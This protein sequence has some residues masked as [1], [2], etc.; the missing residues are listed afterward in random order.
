[1]NT[2]D[3]DKQVIDPM[4]IERLCRCPC[5]ACP[6]SQVSYLEMLPDDCLLA[7]FGHLC[8]Q[9]KV[10]LRLV[11]QRWCRLLR[12]QLNVMQKR[13][14]VWYPIDNDVIAMH[15]FQQIH[16]PHLLPRR[17][18]AI[19]NGNGCLTLFKGLRKLRLLGVQLPSRRASIQQLLSPTL[20]HLALLY[21]N[22]PIDSLVAEAAELCIELKELELLC[23]G[24]HSLHEPTLDRVLLNLKKLHTLR[25]G[26]VWNSVGWAHPVRCERLPEVAGRLKAL[27]LSDCEDFRPPVFFAMLCAATV[28]QQL[29]SLQFD[30]RDSV[31]GRQLEY[32]C[33]MLPS[34]ESLVICVSRPDCVTDAQ[35]G[36]IER[37]HLL[38]RL[39][40]VLRAPVSLTEQTLQR[41][42][43]G[44]PAV[45]MFGIVHFG[46]LLGER[47]LIHLA[48]YWPHLETLIFRCNH[49]LR[50][51]S[52]QKLH[53]LR[54]LRRLYLFNHELS[55]QLR[56]LLPSL[57]AIQ[58]LDVRSA[59]SINR[60][61]VDFMLD[62]LQNRPN[63]RFHL[64]ISDRTRIDLRRYELNSKLWPQLSIHRLCD[65]WPFDKYA[66]V[67]H[68]NFRH[69]YEPI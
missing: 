13:M 49:A 24:S 67:M 17:S 18:V 55:N 29:K 61:T 45:R 30:L 60:E 40:L 3:K 33:L 57:P 1:M 36:H 37:L 46:P 2:D 12:V 47:T 48:S 27:Q 54:Q 68:E 63:D 32:V 66:M 4:L 21:C 58:L 11:S 42:M 39:E 43:V 41:I 44:C 62:W 28:T 15:D 16:W 8:I 35:F 5:P 50:P 9:E 10:R 38:Q 22:S 23:V 25:I 51:A 20:N 7:V 19:A 6:D 52:L 64:L 59:R 31:S 69:F 56:F 65:S 53:P 14:T 26:F 34:L